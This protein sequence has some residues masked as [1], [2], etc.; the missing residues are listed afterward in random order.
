MDCIRQVVDLLR[1]KAGQF[2]WQ[3]FATEWDRAKHYL[4]KTDCL[5]ERLIGEAEKAG[6]REQADSLF[7]EWLA[8]RQPKILEIER[9]ETKYLS[10]AGKEPRRDSSASRR[11][12]L[13]GVRREVGGAA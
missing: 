8:K 5:Y 11:P 13:V 10:E 4:A 12:R 1:A 2:F 9:L 3:H 7:A 6:K